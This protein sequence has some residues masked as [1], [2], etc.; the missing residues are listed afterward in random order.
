MEK[1][2]RDGIMA[3]PSAAVLNDWFRWITENV[4]LPVDY[5]GK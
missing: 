4:K 5:I 1:M 3:A 2:A